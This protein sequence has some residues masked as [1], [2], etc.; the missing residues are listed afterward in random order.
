MAYVSDGSRVCNSSTR[1][2]L[3]AIDADYVLVVKTDPV[4]Y[5]AAIDGATGDRMRVLGAGTF[6]LHWR[7]A[8]GTFAEVTDISEVKLMGPGSTVL[9]NGT[10]VNATTAR[11]NETATFIAGGIEVEGVATSTTTP[12]VELRDE[13]SGEWQFA[14]SFADALDNQAYD[15]RGVVVHDA[16]TT[17]IDFAAGITTTAAAL[18]QLRPDSDI[19]AGTWTSSG[20]NFF[21]VL[22]ESVADDLDFVTSAATPT[23]DVAEV[24]LMDP[25]TNTA[26]TTSI[27]VRVKKL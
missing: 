6:T 17:N 25:A 16:G 1:A 22:D 24:G 8:A 4:I 15:F 27:H 3:A 7:R 10:A 11:C 2:A 21:S 26:G 13:N 20:A 5:C 9:V 23:N 18:V 19:S 12:L 14:L